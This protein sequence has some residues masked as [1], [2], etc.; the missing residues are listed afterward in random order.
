MNYAQI[1]ICS[2]VVQDVLGAQQHLH[3]LVDRE[4]QLRRRDQDVVAAFRILSV[5]AERIV[6]RDEGRVA[7]AELTVVAGE[8]EAPVPLLAERLDDRRVLGDL[9]ELAPDEESRRQ[10]RGDADGGDDREPPLELLVLGVVFRLVALAVAVLPDDPGQE[11]VDGDEHHARDPEREDHG[12]VHGGPVRRDRREPPGAREVEYQGADDEED[13]DNCNRHRVAPLLS[14]HPIAWCPPPPDGRERVYEMA[15]E[16]RE[17]GLGM[18][19]A[20]HVPDH[21]LLVAT[22]VDQDQEPA[23]LDVVV[24][25]LQLLVLLLDADQAAFPGAEQRRHAAQRD[26]DEPGDVLERPELVEHDAADHAGEQADGGAEEAL[27]DEVERLEVVAGVDMPLLE[28]GLVL[29]DHV[30]EKVVDPDIVQVVGDPRGAVELR[31]DVIETLHPYPQR[32]PSESSAY[33]S[34]GGTPGCRMQIP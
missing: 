34:L 9:H 22:R 14:A 31:C 25:P 28:S 30:D 32:P 19:P 23:G 3:R 13:Q 1:V 17:L 29:G 7:V 16:A 21:R 18:A 15:V 5:E 6:G 20:H 11:Q 27:A 24:E 4:A 10:H 12:V 33:R 8:P 26:V 2:K